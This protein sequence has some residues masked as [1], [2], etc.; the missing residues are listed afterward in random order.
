MEATQLNWKEM[1]TFKMLDIK[2]NRWDGN[3]FSVVFILK[4]IDN[5]RFSTIIKTYNKNTDLLSP[6]VLTKYFHKHFSENHFSH[7]IHLWFFT[8]YFTIF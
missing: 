2:S 1:L 4:I 3:K 6:L 5:R 7:F 8:N